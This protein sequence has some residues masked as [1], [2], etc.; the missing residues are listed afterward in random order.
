M[1]LGADRASVVRMM[2]GD[3]AKLLAIGLPLG[4]GLAVAGARFAATLLY[5]V[6]AWDPLTLALAT[7]ALGLVALVASWIPA[8]RASRLE[9]TIA[10]RQE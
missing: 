3:A 4:A 2:L 6:P 9:P 8:L 10:L 7:A 5:G 1:A